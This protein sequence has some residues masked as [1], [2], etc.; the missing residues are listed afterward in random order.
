VGGISVC[1]QNGQ[2]GTGKKL[3]GVG[4]AWALAHRE[5]IETRSAAADEDD[6][7]DGSEYIL[8]N[9]D[10][11]PPPRPAP[12]PEKHYYVHPKNWQAYQVFR[13]C[14]SQWR[15]VAG[16]GGIAYQGLDYPSVWTV[17]KAQRCKRPHRIFRQIQLIEAGALSKING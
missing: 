1:L 16:M 11:R 14:F 9:A 4:V 17:I 7:S 2:A 12:P 13:H 15:V 10:Q 8:L 5:L 3:T 6:D